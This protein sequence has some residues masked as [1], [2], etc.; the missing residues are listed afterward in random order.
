MSTH[1]SALRRLSSLVLV[2]VLATCGDRQ[3]TEPS[4]P[5][6]SAP[7]S[8]P[9][10]DDAPRGAL[11]VTTRT[12]GPLA[13]TEYIL[14]VEGRYQGVITD[15]QEVTIGELFPGRHS[16]ELDAVAAHCSLAGTNPRTAEVAAGEQVRLVFE[17]TCHA[18][19]LGVVTITTGEAL[20]EDGY[21]LIAPGTTVTLPISGRVTVQVPAVP[22]TIVLEGVAINCDVRGSNSRDLFPLSGDT[23]PVVFEI[24]CSES[25]PAAGVVFVAG[26]L[27]TTD[28]FRYPHDAFDP[29]NLTL[30]PAN[31]TDPAVSPD[32]TRIAFVSDR[33][34]TAD[35]FV[36][37]ADGSDP[38]NLT[39]GSA[40]NYGPTWS[41]DGTRIAFT[42]DRAPDTDDFDVYVMDADG[43]N[44]VR[45][46][47][48]PGWDADPAWSPDGTRIAFSTNRDGDYEVYVMSAD[49]SDQTNLT[50][51]PSSGWWFESS[52]AWSPDGTM[53]AFETD[54]DLLW[55]SSIYVMNADGSKQRPLITDGELAWL[56]GP[57]WKPDGTRVAASFG[58]YG[59][60]YLILVRPDGSDRR[61]PPV[62]PDYRGSVS[63]GP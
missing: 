19:T 45:I 32:G 59:T 46:T 47:D 39:G 36:M 16:V 38:V 48:S 15:D 14:R 63:W 28:I 60:G 10:S 50:N 41:P 54:R 33:A 57:T 43:G 22:T 11:L 52:P 51:N 7:D 30:H 12:T 25:S 42:S 8:S 13:D 55:G 26:A 21:S 20:D 17:V 6:P 53:I 23:T 4:A 9:P 24:D 49:G 62:P 29:V 61:H 44:V 1:S 31:D 37:E 56:V 34:G 3:P 18:A 5:D 27:G 58:G 2:A 40:V 35:I